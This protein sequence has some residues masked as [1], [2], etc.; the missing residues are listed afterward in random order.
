[1][2]KEMDEMEKLVKRVE[3][4]DLR[5]GDLIIVRWRDASDT[6]GFIEDFGSPQWCKDWGF[7]L[8]VVGRKHLEICISKDVAEGHPAWGVS[9]IPVE[10]IDEIWLWIPCEETKKLVPELNFSGRRFRTRRYSRESY[11]EDVHGA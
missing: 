3:L 10:L 11:L 1:M 7:Y 4:E 9:R 8:G 2:M 6:R 5:R